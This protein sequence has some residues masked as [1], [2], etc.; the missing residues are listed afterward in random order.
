M[1]LEDEKFCEFLN[2]FQDNLHN[3]TFSEYENASFD[4]YDSNRSTK[5]KKVV[6]AKID[7]N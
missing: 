5:D 7:I 3:K 1:N 6:L 4:T 2:A